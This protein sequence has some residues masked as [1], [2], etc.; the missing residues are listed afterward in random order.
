LAAFLATA[1]ACLFGVGS[2]SCPRL[3]R[4][5]LCPAFSAFNAGIDPGAVTMLAR[6]RQFFVQLKIQY[7][8]VR[9]F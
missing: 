4:D 2:P 7:D 5:G 8:E 6:D 9:Q 3:L 1:A